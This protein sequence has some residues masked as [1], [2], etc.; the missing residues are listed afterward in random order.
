[1]RHTKQYLDYIQSDEWRMR[2][3]II[4][5]ERG[6]ACEECGCTDEHLQLH[7]LTYD[8]LG[9][10]LDEDLQLL[11]HDCHEIADEVR[12][13]ETIY[14][15]AKATY[16]EKKYDGDPPE[17]IDEEFDEWLERKREEDY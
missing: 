9:A 1:M 11:C 12:V 15:R 14:E 13:G 16:I 2:K 10:E 4:I 5:E 8:R 3:A 6:Y 7:H 17:D